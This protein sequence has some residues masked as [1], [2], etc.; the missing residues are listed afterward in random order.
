MNLKTNNMNVTN[1]EQDILRNIKA[2]Q[3]ANRVQ[4]HQYGL[5]LANRPRKKLKGYQKLNKNKK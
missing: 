5:Y 4:P 3:H 2:Q 1:L